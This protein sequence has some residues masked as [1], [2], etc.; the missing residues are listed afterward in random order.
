MTYVLISLISYLQKRPY[1]N[2][3]YFCSNCN[4][5]LLKMLGLLLDWC[6]WGGTLADST[7]S[8]LF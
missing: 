1:L 6:D 8:L 4:P 7:H 5:I 2:C 3:V